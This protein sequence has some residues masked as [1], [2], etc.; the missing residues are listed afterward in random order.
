[1]KKC[2]FFGVLFHF[3]YFAQAQ[4]GSDAYAPP[5][6]VPQAPEVASLLKFTE[7]PVSY[8]TGVPNISIPI[9]SISGRELSA[10]VSVSYHAG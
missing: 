8:H 5:S 9:A 6:I 4:F 1:M 2:I 10:S 3:C 7:T